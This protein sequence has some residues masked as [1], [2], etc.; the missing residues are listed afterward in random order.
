MYRSGSMPINTSIHKQRHQK[1]MLDPE[2]RESYERATREI[3]QIDTV[4]RTLDDLRDSTGMSKAELARRVHRNPAVVRR[5]FT[6]QN[7]RPEL[8]LV[9]S[10]ADALNADVKVIPRDQKDT[11]PPLAA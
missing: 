3:Q 7:A 8:T 4:I 5:L 1:R 6:A 11:Q 2:Y 10:I 9:A